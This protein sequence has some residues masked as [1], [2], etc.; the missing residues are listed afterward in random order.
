MTF[1]TWWRLRLFFTLVWIQKHHPIA[2]PIRI[3]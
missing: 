3:R 2:K 1:G